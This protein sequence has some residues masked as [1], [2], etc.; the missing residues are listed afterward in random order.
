V[1]GRF[2][3]RDVITPVW[4][5]V[6]SRLFVVFSILGFIVAGLL[7]AWVFR[8]WSGRAATAAELRPGRSALIGLGLLL[9][10]PILVLPLFLT[11]VGIPVAL[12]IL[13]VWLCAL[14]LG[15]LPA[16]T[17]AGTRL[18]RGRGGFA[19]ALV[20]G[21]LVWR[22][23]MWLLPLI[24]LLLYLAALLIGLGAYGSAAWQLRRESAAV[25]ANPSGK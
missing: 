19:A 3:R 15:P 22:G 4:A 16:V 2:T 1:N 20:V 10:P 13:I 21:T 6:A 8:G 11:L 5:Q 17:A 14:F 23:A 25:P 9:V 7:A 24:A 12:V 18:L